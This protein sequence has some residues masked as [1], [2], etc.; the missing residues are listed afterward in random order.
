MSSGPDTSAPVNENEKYFAVFK[1]KLGYHRLL[2]CAEMDGVHPDPT[3]PKRY[4]ELKTSRIITGERQ[5]RNF[6]RLVT[7]SMSF[8]LVFSKIHLQMNFFNA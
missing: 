2:F 4:V 3:P 7:F 8:I 6:R 5:E 1:G